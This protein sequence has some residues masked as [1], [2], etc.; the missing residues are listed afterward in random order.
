ME[1]FS[2]HLIEEREERYLRIATTIG[3]G[4]VVCSKATTL[5]NGRQ[6]IIEFSSTGVVFVR[7]VDKTLVTLYVT[8]IAM[9]RKYLH[10]S[11]PIKLM[12][13]IKRNQQKGYCNF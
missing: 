13:V 2:K 11:I 1:K 9:A 8:T 6:G 4:T 12:Q 7:G 3:F 10:D 5:S